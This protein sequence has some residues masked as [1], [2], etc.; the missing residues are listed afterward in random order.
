MGARNP[1]PSAL[2][3][4]PYELGFVLPHA[5]ASVLGNPVRPAARPPRPGTL[6]RKLHACT[7][8]NAMSSGNE[9]RRR[10]LAEGTAQ[11]RTLGQVPCQCSS[12]PLPCPPSDWQ[13]ISETALI[14][15]WVRDYNIHI[16]WPSV[17]CSCNC[18]CQIPAFS[19]PT[20]RPRTT[21]LETDSNFTPRHIWSKLV[22]A[23]G[24]A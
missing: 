4:H 1:T 23:H 18:H 24:A 5:L 19:I 2:S 21:R 3:I 16:K 22:A 15:C 11:R 17:P 7:P 9:C 20:P 13:T 14:T 8:H 6:V 12:E 10:S